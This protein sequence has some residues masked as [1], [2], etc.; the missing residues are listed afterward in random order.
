MQGDLVDILGHEN[1]K[2]IPFLVDEG[3]ELEEVLEENLDERGLSVLVDRAVVGEDG[4]AVEDWQ[5]LW[6]G[7]NF[8]EPILD[9]IG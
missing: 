7:G 1:D 5:D 3:F 9:H 8:D 6:V 2:M 4:K